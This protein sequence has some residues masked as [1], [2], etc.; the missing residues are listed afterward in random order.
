MSKK[1]RTIDVA[2]EL[3]K[4]RGLERDLKT[5]L[6][7]SRR[8][9]HQLNIFLGVLA[10]A[11]VVAVAGLTPLKEPAK[12]HII[13]VNDTTGAIEHITSL[14]DTPESYGERIDKYFLN[15]YVLN[16]EGYN[17]YTIQEQFDTCALLSSPPIQA[18]YGKRFEGPNAPTERL[19]QLSNLD[20]E[21]HSITMGTNQT[22]TVRFSTAQRDVSSG[23]NEK[24]RHQIATVAYEYLQVPLSESVARR[25]PLGFQVIRYDLAAD[26]SR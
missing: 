22:A 26:L 21:V 20:V 23:R 10:F 3:E 19:G 18:Q 2:E 17:W 1:L 13:R 6:I 15:T 9:A 14:G 8:R 25:N 5:E 7:S 16:C 11:G 12:P 4:S 24:E